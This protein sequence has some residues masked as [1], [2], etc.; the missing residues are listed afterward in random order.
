MSSVGKKKDI[1]PYWRPDYRNP[2]TLPDIKVVRTDFIV[3]FVAILLALAV[4]AF[5]LQREYR[6]WS[7][8]STVDDMKQRIRVTEP[9]DNISIKQ[10]EEFRKAGRYIQDLEKFYQAPFYAHEL[11]VS[12]SELEEDDLIFTNLRFSE[13]TIT[14]NKKPVVEY[15][16]E[17]A[18]Q[19]R[20]LPT[21]DDYVVSL[22][23]LELFDVEGYEARVAE[24]PRQ[25]DATGLYPY[26]ISVTLSPSAEKKKGGK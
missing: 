8:G 17:I 10:S 15:S 9:D 23:N 24:D 21:L 25:R 12:L 1:Q 16:M 6:V 26:T 13:N 7:I 14:Q 4:G 19:V 5:L 22:R 20:D 2:S 3:N 11:L 18:G